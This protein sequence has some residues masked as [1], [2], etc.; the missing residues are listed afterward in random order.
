MTIDQDVIT[1][2]I[3]D[4][5]DAAAVAGWN[6]DDAK[7]TKAKEALKAV[8]FEAQQNRCFYCRRRIKDMLGHSELDH[9]LPK[10]GRGRIPARLVSNERSDRKNTV[11]YSRFT[12][13]PLNLV[14]SCKPCNTAKGTYDSR[15]DRSIDALEE[16]VSDDGNYY[17][18]VHP[19]IHAYEDHIILLKGLIYQPAQGSINGDAVISACKLASV[20][21]VERMA[22]EKKVKEATKVKKAFILL[23]EESELH[24]WDYLVGL[25]CGQFPNESVARIRE[26]GESVRDFAG[27]D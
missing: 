10:D 1:A 5:F 26:I 4:L 21:A 23:L 20:A 15:S 27:D 3:R 8:M 22:C 17:E 2:Q 18:W 12:F 19:F 24:D 6:W 25:V 16:Y 9:I 13:E 11:G 7:A 14:L